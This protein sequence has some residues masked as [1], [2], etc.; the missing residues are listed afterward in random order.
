MLVELQRN[1]VPI[2]LKT[3]SYPGI[4]VDDVACC[5]KRSTEKQKEKLCRKGTE[6]TVLM[7]SKYGNNKLK[8]EC[9]ACLIKQLIA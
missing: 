5:F 2:A 3:H 9:P 4:V 7:V 8:I 6:L 1:V